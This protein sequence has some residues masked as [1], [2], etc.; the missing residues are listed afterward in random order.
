MQIRAMRRDKRPAYTRA[1]R[2]DVTVDAQAEQVERD[3]PCERVAVGVHPGR[4]HAD[5]R[6]ADGDGAA[7][8][9]ALAIDDADDKAREIVF[10]IGIDTRHLRGLATE[11]RA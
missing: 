9:Q 3:P 8:D 6:I 4:G 1:Q 11:E 10:A 5:E 7:V 2:V